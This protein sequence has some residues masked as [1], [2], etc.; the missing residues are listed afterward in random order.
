M[1][2]L[3]CV[4]IA[5]L[6][7]GG[8]D[9]PSKRLGPAASKAD[10]GSAPGGA[11]KFD[12]I[13]RPIE[14]S[15]TPVSPEGFQALRWGMTRAQAQRAMPG[16][17]LAADGED[18]RWTSNVAGHR[19]RIDGFFA[20]NRLAVVAVTFGPGLYDELYAS[21]K[22]KYGTVEDGPD[23]DPTERWWWAPETSVQIE[24]KLLSTEVTY[25][26]RRPQEKEAVERR[27]EREAKAR[28]R[29]L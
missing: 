1:G 7:D 23:T 14:V 3:L 9:D 28:A 29:D 5:A 17:T 10:A 21:L 22:S 26:S 12:E 20:E 25:R 15:T 4:G 18:L 11:A 16:A 24:L 27:I 8:V 13:G 6:A 2:W 19:A